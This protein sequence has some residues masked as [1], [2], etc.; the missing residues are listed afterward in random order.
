MF[1]AHLT[2]DIPLEDLQL[3]LATEEVD[4]PVVSAPKKSRFGLIASGVVVSGGF[5]I[6]MAAAA[7]LIV[8][9]GTGA[10]LFL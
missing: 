10:Y 4:L 1:A 3:L 5:A 8:A 6:G 7:A 2:D 9:V